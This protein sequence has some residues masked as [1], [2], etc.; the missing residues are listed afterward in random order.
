MVNLKVATRPRKLA[1]DEVPGPRHK[2]FVPEG[3]LEPGK[4]RY[5]PSPAGTVESSGISIERT[6][7]PPRW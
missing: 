5:H 2:T 7:T 4:V 1:T 6:L 3:Q